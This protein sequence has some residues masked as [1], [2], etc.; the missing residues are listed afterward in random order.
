MIPKRGKSM[1]HK[2][3][4]RIVKESDKAILFIHGIAGTPNHFKPFISLV[5]ESVSVYNLLLDGH[6]KGVKDF[7]HT[8]MTKWEM[9]V[10]NAVDEL[11]Q[12]HEKIYLVAHS[13]GTLFSIEQAVRRKEIAGL[14]LLAVPIK[15]FL[16]P[17]MFSNSLKVYFNKI[18]PDDFVACAAKECYGIEQD[19][20]PLNYIGW[21]PR[22]LELFAKIRSTRK[23][24]SSLKTP[25]KVFQS[26]KD[27]MVSVKSIPYLTQHSS[28]IITELKMSGHYY[29]DKEDFDFLLKEFKEFLTP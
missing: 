18:K 16:K 6:G 7:S 10:Q 13:M 9:Q 22:Y 12:C 20:N 11:L 25:C 2:E 4:K 15:L 1:Q 27:E 26:V 24:L 3:F 19:R 23:I 5:P 17:K 14:F 29:Y 8:S 28:M 21:I